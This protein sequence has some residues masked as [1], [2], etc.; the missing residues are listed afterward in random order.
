MVAIPAGALVGVP[1]GRTVATPVYAGEVLVEDRLAPAGSRGVAAL[2]PEGWR[3]VAVPV[4]AAALPV[5]VGDR[6]DVL[7]VVDET[8]SGRDVPAYVVSS[9]A[10]VV[11]V[12][13]Q[14]VTVAVPV[15]DAPSL[16][17][18]MAAG[19]VTLALAPV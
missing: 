3:A 10:L 17:F 16:A 6:V 15:D 1:V 11:G 18:A 12:T 5:L 8:V 19:V 9:G 13:D 4:G 14:A 7:A 2:V